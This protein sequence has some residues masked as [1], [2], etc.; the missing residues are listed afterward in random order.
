M[1]EGFRYLGFDLKSNNYD[2][3]DWDWLLTKF[4]KKL[5]GLTHRC[6]SLGG[7]LI[8]IK[9]VLQSI[10]VIWMHLFMLP[11]EIIHRINAIIAR[12]L[13]AGSSQV[14]KFHLVHLFVLACSIEAKGWGIL[15]I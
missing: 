9:S 14:R 13:W 2:I 3:H 15:D 12:F 10:S 5:A 4:Q 6:L 1:D 7:R 11:K 8:L